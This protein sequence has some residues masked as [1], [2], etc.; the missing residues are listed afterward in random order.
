MPPPPLIPNQHARMPPPNSTSTPNAKGK[1]PMAP[2]GLPTPMQ[3]PVGVTA[4]ARAAQASA[5]VGGMAQ[6]NAERHAARL[7]AIQDAQEAQRREDEV[8]AQAAAAQSSDQPLAPEPN[9]PQEV[10]STSATTSI[11]PP[12]RV[13]PK[14]STTS[15]LDSDDFFHFPSDDD[16]YFANLD[17]NALDEGVG[18]PIDYDE[19]TSAAIG[20][21]PDDDASMSGTSASTH[22]GVAVSERAV[23]PQPPQPPQPQAQQAQRPPQQQRSRVTSGG[24]ARPSTSHQNQNIPPA[25][26]A[27]PAKPSSSSERPRTPSMGGGFSFPSGVSPPDRPLSASRTH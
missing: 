26:H 7:K 6:R 18:G 5:N 9:V 24:S 22:A 27:P 10:P 19:G 16:A 15:A 11:Q 21:D 17:M 4:Q 12:P 8:A 2:A 25:N 13:L 14:T 20:P 1:A 3:T 23:P